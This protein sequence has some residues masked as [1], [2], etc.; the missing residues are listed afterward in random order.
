MKFLKIIF[1]CGRIRQ[2]ALYENRGFLLVVVTLKSRFFCFFVTGC[3]VE[4]F[5][6]VF[7]AVRKIQEI[8]VSGRTCK[9]SSCKLLPAHRVL[10][11]FVVTSK[12]KHENSPQLCKLIL[13]FKNC[14]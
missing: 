5:C 12:S 11:L 14:F 3:K 13:K 1:E 4:F 2:S 7:L 8:F 6:V 9:S 10:F